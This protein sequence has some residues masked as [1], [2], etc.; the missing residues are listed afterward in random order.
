MPISIDKAMNTS[1]PLFATTQLFLNPGHESPTGK[2]PNLKTPGH[3]ISL[4]ATSGA[5]RGSDVNGPF[6]SCRSQDNASADGFARWTIADD[7]DGIFWARPAQYSIL[8][9]LMPSGGIGTSQLAL[10]FRDN[11]TQGVNSLMKLGVSGASNGA[12]RF[13]EKIVK[14]ETGYGVDVE[15]PGGQ[16]A[17]FPGSSTTIMAMGIRRGATTA[18][19]YRSDA[20]NSPLSVTVPALSATPQ[21]CARMS[22]GADL[23]VGGT[24][25]YKQ[26]V[27]RTIFFDS[28]IGDTAMKTLLA[29][30]GESMLGAAAPVSATKLRAKV[31]VRQGQTLPTGVTNVKVILWKEQASPL[32]GSCGFQGATTTA[33]QVFLAQ[34]LGAG[35]DEAHLLIDLTVDFDTFDIGEKCF[36]AIY[37][38]PFDTGFGAIV[39]FVGE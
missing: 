33:G 36:G 1:H 20:P 37:T 14:T 16:A 22:I 11:A 12:A 13:R 30:W 3:L 24:H 29:D 8:H 17:I 5:V 35:N 25:S 27:Y 4:G 15:I 39:E 21:N 9:V 2:T 19:F 32:I 26:R 6:I 18:T 28:D 10:D 23:E 31:K 34:V 38:T 7:T